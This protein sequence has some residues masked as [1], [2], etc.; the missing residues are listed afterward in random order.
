MD[1]IDVFT[2]SMERIRVNPFA[3][4][5]LK[6]SDSVLSECWFFTA[7]QRMAMSSSINPQ[8]FMKKC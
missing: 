2:S 1:V 3:I 7:L 5:L 6:S 8:S 4:T